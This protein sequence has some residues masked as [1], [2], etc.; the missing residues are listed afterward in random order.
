MT[1]RKRK[2]KAVKKQGVQAI[3]FI[4][5]D[6]PDFSTD[7]EEGKLGNLKK[8][9]SAVNM[10]ES[11]VLWMYANDRLD[12][13]Q[14]AAAGQFR[15]YYERRGFSIQAIDYGKQPVD[16]G[17][18]HSEGITDEMKQASEEL[19][20]ARAKLGDQGFTLVEKVCGQLLWIN[21]I[22]DKKHHQLRAARDLRDCLDTLAIFWGLAT[23]KT[24]YD[25]KAG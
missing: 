1:K 25:R 16:G 5:V 23:V 4:E 2:P 3:R 11:P 12:E 14:L 24:D 9:K 21:Q 10:R 22:E 15:R 8:I 18:I 6:D 7:H 19:E 17:A 20:G 13:T